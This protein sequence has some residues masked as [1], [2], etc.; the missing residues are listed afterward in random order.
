MTKHEKELGKILTRED[1]LEAEDL[2]LEPCPVPEWGGTVLIRGLSGTERDALE[3]DSVMRKGKNVQVNLKNLR[4]KLA[5][6]TIVDE[7]G[8]RIFKLSDV[9]ALGK[10]SA[11]ALDRVFEVASRLSGLTEEDVEELVANFGE[12]QSDGSTSD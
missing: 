12:D 2:G 5:A 9:E 6:R 7:K 1:I 11:A 3:S 10:K 8:N 4:A